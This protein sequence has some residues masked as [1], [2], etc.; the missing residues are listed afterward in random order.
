MV[1]IPETTVTGGT[2]IKIKAEF[3]NQS[4]G[5]KETHLY[6]WAVNY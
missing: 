6:G 4:A 3:A 5:S 1:R 2:S